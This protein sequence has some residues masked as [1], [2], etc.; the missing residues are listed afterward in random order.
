MINDRLLNLFHYRLNF[1]FK[2]SI[3]NYITPLQKRLP[4][5]Q[6]TR[7][8]DPLRKTRGRKRTKRELRWYN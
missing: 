4:R 7:N 2:T 1:F 5:K 6:N 8:A 3:T